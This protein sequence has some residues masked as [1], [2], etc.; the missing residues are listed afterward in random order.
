MIA[1]PLVYY[2][3]KLVTLLLDMLVSPILALLALLQRTFPDPQDRQ[4]TSIPHHQQRPERV[5]ALVCPV[6]LF[7]R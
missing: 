6:A 2:I 1:Y 4:K 7:R 3:V 5:P